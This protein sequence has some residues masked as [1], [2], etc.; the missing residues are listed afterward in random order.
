MPVSKTKSPHVSDHWENAMK[1]VLP[2]VCKITTNNGTGTGFVLTVNGHEANQVYGLAT[3]YHVISTAFELDMPIRITHYSSN[4]SVVLK[5]DP[6]SRIII[7]IP[8]VDLAFILFNKS[9]I[10]IDIAPV[11]LMEQGSETISGKE[12]GWV[13]FPSVAPNQACFFH[14]YISA[15]YQFG[16]VVGNLVD[17]VVIHG[18]SGGPTFYLAGNQPKICGVLT[19]YLPNY[20]IGQSLPGLGFISSV[21]PFQQTISELKNLD[22]ARKAAEQQQQ[23]NANTPTPSASPPG[24]ETRK[25]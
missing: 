12:I 19:Q 3:A 10:A 6:N 4:N 21:E 24:S 9:S 8:N 20:A 13:G 15:P 25:I 16:S 5:A 23:V 18:V 7:P 1:A 14:G 17:G 2:S 22:E 11:E